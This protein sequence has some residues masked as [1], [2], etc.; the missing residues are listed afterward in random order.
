MGR[1]SGKKPS[2]AMVTSILA[3]VLAVAGTSVAAVSAL[4][5][6]EKKQVSKIAKKEIKKAAPGLSV[7]KVDGKDAAQLQTTSAYA[8]RSADDFPLTASFQDVVT[9]SVTATAAARVIATASLELDAG[10]ATSAHCRLRI[11]GVEGFT[12]D[13]Q[14][15]PTESTMALT[16]ARSVPAGTHA[17]GLECSETGSVIDVDASLSVIAVPE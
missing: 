17:V 15:L 8:E 9:T 1:F 13:S 6:S 14:A 2:P 12:Y 4:T 3:L 5:K 7:D 11:A 16:F 10:A